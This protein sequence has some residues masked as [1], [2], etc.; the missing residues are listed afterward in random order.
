MVE[1]SEPAGRDVE[2]DTAQLKRL[3]NEIIGQ[4]IWVRLVEVDG[5]LKIHMVRDSLPEWEVA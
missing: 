4:N 3:M 2:A 5:E 1:P